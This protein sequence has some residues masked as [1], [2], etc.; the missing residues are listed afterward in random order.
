MP[1]RPAG[2][3]NTRGSDG[4]TVREHDLQLA[5]DHIP[6]LAAGVPVLYDALGGQVKHLAQGIVIGERWFVF[7]NLAELAVQP[8]DD[9]RRVN[10]PADLRRIVEEGAQNLPV[11]LPTFY[12]DLLRKVK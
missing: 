6:V 9:V 5:E 10:D 8:F 4:S 3:N 7:G 2:N 11:L 1:R 12:A